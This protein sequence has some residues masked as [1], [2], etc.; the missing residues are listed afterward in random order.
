MIKP[1][2]TGFP[3]FI[4]VL[5]G[6]TIS[7]LGSGLTGFAL[8]IWVYQQTDAA[9]ALTLLGFSFITP[10]LIF[11]PFAGAIVDRS[12]RKL[13]M[14]LSDLAAGLS[15]IVVL[16]L[17]AS[18]NLEIWHLYIT[19]AVNGLFHAFQWPAY[20]AAITT[21][22]PKEHYGRASGMMSLV[23]MGPG[24]LAPLLAAA[25][26]GTLG[27]VGILLIDVLTFIVAILALLVVV[28]PQP[29]KT[30]EGQKV[31]GSLAREA[32]YGF[33][34]ILARPSLL[35]LQLVFLFGN[36]AINIPYAV[37]VAMMLARSSQDIN[38]LAAVNTIGAIGGIAGG[39]L[40]SAWGGPRPRVHGVLGG[41]MISGVIATVMGLGTGILVWGT[42]T[43]LSSLLIPILN[44]S[45]Q[46]IWQAKVAPDIQGRVFSI[47]RLIAWFVSPIS[48]LIAGPLADRVLEP[49][50]ATDAAM[51]DLFSPLVGSGPGSGMALMF[52]FCGLL[53]LL[54]GLVAYGV[55]AVRQAE[56]ILP[57]HEAS[58]AA[59]TD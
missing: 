38:T 1:R 2:L 49:M 35:G 59:P 53:A 36:F 17:Y 51:M 8:P 58:V 12:N 18:G 7:L 56:T 43:F 40:M 46:A 21:M 47:R 45:N 33:E 9:T 29:A 41:W 24:L 15:T 25:L 14:M 5:I 32:V 50:M 34:Y 27:L 11:S 55:P 23:E 31:Q 19:N 42:A 48:M 52:V 4:L 26:L 10:L 20:S 54:V 57:D 44:G 22:V 6:Q 30:E 13:M 37:V 28:V 16:V 3:A 39:I